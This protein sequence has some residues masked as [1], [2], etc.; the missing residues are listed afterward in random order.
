[1]ARTSRP[2][3]YNA[4]PHRAWLRE[5]VYRSQRW[6]G[7]K[8]HEPQHDITQGLLHI[9]RVPSG[10]TLVKLP[11]KRPSV[12]DPILAHFR[13]TEGLATIQAELKNSAVWPFSQL[14]SV[15]THAISTSRSAL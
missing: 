11:N 4:E 2:C 5:E 3:I 10:P 13:V 14:H 6:E 9:G 12:N 1:M 8:C 7:E 15:G